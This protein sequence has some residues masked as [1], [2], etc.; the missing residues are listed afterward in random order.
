[1]YVF[2]LKFDEVE[3]MLG[4]VGWFVYIECMML[5]FWDLLVGWEFFVYSYFYE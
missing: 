5:V 1:M 2:V 3:V 4:F